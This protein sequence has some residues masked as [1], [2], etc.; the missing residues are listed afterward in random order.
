M[1]VYDF[2]CPKCESTF[3]IHNNI[4]APVPDAP[5]CKCGEQMTRIYNLG[6]VTFKGSGFY[7]NDK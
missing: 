4:D 3:S 1:P 6:A 2:K 7:K 5:K